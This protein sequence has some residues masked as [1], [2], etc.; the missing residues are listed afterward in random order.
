MFL[1]ME[2]IMFYEALKG[3]FSLQIYVFVK[4]STKYLITMITLN[5]NDLNLISKLHEILGLVLRIQRVHYQLLLTNI[6]II[7]VTMR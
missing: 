5:Q 1:L 3:L 7:Q 4:A 2:D 6:L